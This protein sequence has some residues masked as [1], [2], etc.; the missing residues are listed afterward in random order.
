[1]SPSNSSSSSWSPGPRPPPGHSIAPV[2]VPGSSVVPE[3]SLVPAESVAL[4]SVVAGAPVV[5]VVVVEPVVAGPS[6]VGS[7][8]APVSLPLPPAVGDVLPADVAP[9]LSLLPVLASVSVLSPSVL[10]TVVPG[11]PPLHP[12]VMHRIKPQAA[13]S[14]RRCMAGVYDVDARRS[15][16]VSAGVRGDVRAGVRVGRRERHAGVTGRPALLLCAAMS[17][18]LYGANG[19]GSSVVEATLRE[20]GV[21]YELRAVDVAN[22]AQRGAAYTRINPSRKL[23]TLIS[24]QGETLTESAAILLTLVERHPEAELLPPIG[25]PDRARAL[26]W[27]LFVAGELYPVME[28]I[29]HPERFAG[30]GARAELRETALALWRQRWRLVEDELSEGPYLLGARFCVADI[31]LAALSR[32]DMPRAWRLEHLPKLERLADTVASRPR[33]RELWPRHF[34]G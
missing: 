12:A 19:S 14:S 13:R 33:L 6:V 18:V 27:L 21:P 17:Y 4:A 20:L 7:A 32:W 2:V 9:T 26:R 31:Y 8:L 30:E 11:E 16:S 3:P 5:A 25:G 34:K 15:P 1:M 10:A 29:D 22:H 23:P 24:P 28:L